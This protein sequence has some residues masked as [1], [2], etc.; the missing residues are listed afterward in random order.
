MYYEPLQVANCR[1]SSEMTGVYSAARS[2]LMRGRQEPQEARLASEPPTSPPPTPIRRAS[3]VP[4]HM[5]AILT[6]VPADEAKLPAGTII[7]AVAAAHGIS[8]ADMKGPRRSTRFVAARQHAMA[9]LVQVRPDLSYPVIG[10]LMN[11]DHTTIIHG[12]RHWPKIAGRYRAQAANLRNQIGIQWTPQ[13]PAEE[14][15]MQESIHS[16][17][18]VVENPLV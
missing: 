4:V 5:A 3:D 2:R 13:N 10:T 12:K 17:L 7:S 6:L 15:A 1:T 11:R 8:M 14:Q 9:L 16:T 18:N